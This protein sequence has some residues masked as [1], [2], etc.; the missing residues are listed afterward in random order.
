MIRLRTAG[1]RAVL[2]ST[3]GLLLACGDDSAPL[4]PATAEPLAPPALSAVSGSWTTGAPMPTRRRGLVAATVNGVIYAIG[5]RGASETNL[6]KVEALN[7][8]TGVWTTRASL[9]ARRAWPSGAAVINGKIYVA[10]GLDG[11]GNA[12]KTLFVYDPAAN[13][14]S[15]R[16]ALPVTSARGAAVA[17][18]GKLWVATPAGASTRMH[19]YDPSTNTWTTRTSGPAGH[20][21]AVAGVINGKIY[22][23]GTMNAD[24]TPSYALSMYDPGAN[25]WTARRTLDVEPI[26][27][28]G[29][30]IGQKFYLVGGAYTLS[31]SGHGIVQVYDAATNYWPYTYPPAMPTPRKFSAATVVYGKLYLLGGWTLPQGPLAANEIFTP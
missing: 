23:A 1:L 12:T 17:L 19:R 7:P 24:G 25:T 3:G 29:Q 8:V 21:Y 13:T 5:G 26:G 16:A 11:N 28:G 4:A 14:W 30:A 18:N 2:L 9:P 22:V 15:T 10:G 20:E 27:A 6:T 31:G